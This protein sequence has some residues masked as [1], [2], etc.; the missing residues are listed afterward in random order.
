MKN[1][2]T[3]KVVEMVKRALALCLILLAQWGAS[4]SGQS[5]RQP[6]LQTQQPSG[7]VEQDGDDDDDVVRVRSEEVVVPISVRDVKGAPVGGLGEER[8]LVYDN[9]VRQEIKSFNR[10]RVPANIVLLLDASGSIFS[11]MRFIREAAK[12]FMRGLSPEDKVCVMQFADK[13]ELLQDWTSA[14]ETGK[15]EKAMDW[16]Y[17]PGEATTFYDGLYLAADE[18]LKRVEGR[19]I[20][21][22]LTD[23]IDTAERRRASFSEALDAVRRAEASVYVVSLTASL[24]ALIE[25]RTGGAWWKRL[26]SGGYDPRLV[27]RY[28]AE[29]ERAEKLL[30]G[31]ATQTGGRIF[32]PLEETDLT[33]A[34]EAIAEELRTQYIIT[35]KPTPRAAAGEWRR[36]NVL[37]APGGYEV[38]AREG[39]TGRI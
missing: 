2:W 25:K 11:Q 23:G 4:A 8:F 39:Y 9:G 28:M 29:I 30:T 10:R 33:P 3:I 36:I 21:V 1:R 31:L 7:A 17:H 12:G 6:V 16:R 24:R 19:R 27:A 5:G 38:A 37:V 35:Y 20:V 13:V 32:L 14:T 15:L 18:Q 22:L 26:L 34:Y